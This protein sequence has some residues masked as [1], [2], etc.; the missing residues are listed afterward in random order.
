MVNRPC[1]TILALSQTD[2]QNLYA[3]NTIMEMSSLSITVRNL[4]SECFWCCLYCRRLKRRSTLR[5]PA[6]Q[7]S[8]LFSTGC[9]NLCINM[10]NLSTKFYI[11]MVSTFCLYKFVVG[12]CVTKAPTKLPF[13]LGIQP[14]CS[15]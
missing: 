6:G 8:I 15:W 13:E 11:N 4:S 10:K 1:Q 5:S 7:L 3:V 2:S 14:I 12:R 9:S